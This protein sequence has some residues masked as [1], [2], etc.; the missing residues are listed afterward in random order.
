[1]SEVKFEPFQKVLVRS[2][3]NQVWSTAF[4]SHEQHSEDGLEYICGGIAWNYCISYEGNEHLL[5]TTDS[6]TPPEPE[7]KFGDKVE[8]SNDKITWTNAVY[9]RKVDGDYPHETVIKNPWGDHPREYHAT[10]CRHADW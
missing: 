3:E 9:I 6:P 5:G 4:F 10:F 8:A 2:T 1:M 7:F